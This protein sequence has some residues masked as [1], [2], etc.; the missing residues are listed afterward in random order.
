MQ[1]YVSID[2]IIHRCCGIKHK[3]PMQGCR[4]CGRIIFC[5]YVESIIIR[6]MSETLKYGRTT[7]SSIDL[8]ETAFYRFG[9]IGL[10][11]ATLVLIVH[12]LYF[13]HFTV[14]DAF[15]SF[16]Y[17]RNFA[18][19]NG[20]VFN[21]GERVAGFTNFL[22]VL[23]EAGFYKLG[24]NIVA[25]T[26]LLGIVSGIF[27]LFLFWRLSQ[28]L[29]DNSFAPKTLMMLLLATN[30]A[31]AISATTGLE[32]Q[33]F[34]MFVFCGI[35]FYISNHQERPS[36][37]PAIFFGLAT[38]T[39]PEGLIFFSLV[40]IY[41]VWKNARNK[42]ILAQTASSWLIPYF[43]IVTP[44][45]VFSY[46]YYGSILPNTFYAKTQTTLDWTTAKHGLAY[47]YDFSKSY[48]IFWLAL[49]SVPAFLTKQKQEWLD[50][51]IWI[52][53]GYSVYILRVGDDW[54]P[55][56]RFIVPIIPILYLVFLAGLIS[57]LK[58]GIEI[59][60]SLLFRIKLFTAAVILVI[61]FSTSLQASIKGHTWTEMRAHG[62][63]TAHITL[64]KWLK[65]N[66][67]PDSKIA[68]MD[69]GMVGYYSDR[70]IIDTLGL[71]STEIARMMHQGQS[72]EEIANYVLRQKPAFIVLVSL[73]SMEHEGFK[74]TWQVNDA[75]I[76]NNP[77]FKSEYKYLF[78]LEHIPL[79]T[80]YD[81]Y[82][83]LVYERTL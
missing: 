80:I 7:Y 46:L 25:A 63:E 21:Q 79:R 11:I 74:S 34:A 67:S 35:F 5:Y 42:N 39:R 16:Q 29:F 47:L 77:S 44:L 4:P 61:V 55:F 72:P 18:N 38:L 41:Q 48:G 14:D 19:G 83:L 13:Y 52:I 10:A 70:R 56:Y 27:S 62:Y 17:A 45:L 59:R 15:I 69:V 20:L 12:Q 68:L 57:F 66:T 28:F 36:S 58:N 32:T 22:L 53:L 76:F 1:I 75:A 49:L 40:L 65:A 24:L 37:L 2:I 9:W 78:E 30:S 43:I 60:S 33:F 82:F 71:V 64:G 54:I 26:K 6:Y 50:F 8:K 81:G 73:T 3:H 23:I 31:F 51:L